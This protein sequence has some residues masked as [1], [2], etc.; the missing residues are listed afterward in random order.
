MVSGQIFL[1]GWCRE[2][3]FLVVFHWTPAHVGIDGNE[4]A[5]ELD[6]TAALRGPMPEE[7]KRMI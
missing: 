1:V 6:K 5:D 4:K 3:G 2:A 7:A